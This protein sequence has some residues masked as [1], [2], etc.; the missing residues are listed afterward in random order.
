LK[1]SFIKNSLRI[2]PLTVKAYELSKLAF[3]VLCF[4]LLSGPLDFLSSLLLESMIPVDLDKL[5]LIKFGRLEDFDLAEEAVGEG[6]DSLRLTFNL[7]SNGV[8]DEFNDKILEINGCGFAGD[9]LEHLLADLLNL[10]SFGIAGLTNGGHL[11]GEGDGE[12]AEEIAIEGFHV[13]VGLN[14]SLPLLDVETE[15]IGSEI[16]TV[17]VG[18]AVLSLNVLN[19]KLDGSVGLVLVL[20]QISKRD[21][22]HT[23]L[24]AVRSDLG[25]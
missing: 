10:R 3:F 4:G 24:Q 7:L 16:H 8:G 5:V 21:R 15:L 19:A 17:E 9:D 25:T 14:E 20:V 1:N 6:I 22:H 13:N 23:S 11:L 12:D 18:E 2:F